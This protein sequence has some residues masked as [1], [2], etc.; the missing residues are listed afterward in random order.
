MKNVYIKYILILTVIGMAGV[1]K[2]Q[3]DPYY[4]HFKFLKQSFNPASAGER[5]DLICVNGVWHSQ[6]RNYNDETPVDRRTGNVNPDAQIQENVA[7]TTY[8]L[9]I[10]GQI[11]SNEGK[12]KLGAVGI[13]VYDDELGFMKSTTARLQAA[14]FIPVQGNFGRLAIG[15]ELGFYQFGFVDP[16]FYPRDPNDPKVPKTGTNDVNF[17]LGFGAYYKQRRL[18]PIEDFYAGLSMSHLT[19]PTYD[20]N[21]NDIVITFNQERHWYVLAGGTYPLNNPSLELEPSVLVKYRAKF[22][23]DLNTTILWNETARAGLGYRQ[24]GNIDALSVLLGYV[25]K[26]IT[27]GYSYDITLSTV[28]TVSD[29]THEFMVAYCFGLPSIEP[30]TPIYKR[31]TR[32]L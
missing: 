1:S 8:A 9:N 12:N 19:A 4:T 20:L 31:G 18:G 22:Q 2:A 17:D 5:D 32:H 7:P 16:K 26:N 27:V 10:S 11:T 14:L 25:W 15:P 24:W 29:G 21:A 3:Q 30:P 6:W 28:R 23:V 13:S